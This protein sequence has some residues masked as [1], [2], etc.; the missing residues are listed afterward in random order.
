MLM[1]MV[2]ASRLLIIM[3]AHPVILSFTSRCSCKKNCYLLFPY[4]S[5]FVVTTIL[6]LIIDC[7][8]R[9]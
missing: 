2:L 7:I 1:D 8:R 3:P 5:S 4:A 6:Q 9:Y